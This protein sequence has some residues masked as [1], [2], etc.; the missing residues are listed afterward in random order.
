VGSLINFPYSADVRGSASQTLAAVYESASISG[1]ELGSMEMAG[2]YL[3]DLALKISQQI[4]EED[5]SVDVETLHAEAEALS[6][7]L[8]SVYI[9]LEDHGEQL[10][11]HYTVREARSVVQ[12]CM[13]ALVSC[14][15][16]R[17]DSASIKY[18]LNGIQPSEDEI[19]VCDELLQGEQELLMPLVDSVGYNL[20]FFRHDFLP[21]FESLVVP[22][23]APYLQPGQDHRARVAAVCLFD[24]CIEHCGIAAASKFAPV[25]I[26]GAVSGLEDVSE[27]QDLLRASIYGIAQISR[28]CPSSVLR[29][30][31]ARIVPRLASILKGS[32]REGNEAVFENT[33]STLA[34]LTL[35]GSPPFL[36]NQVLAREEFL[37]ILLQNSPLTVDYDESKICN[38]GLCDLIDKGAIP[39]DVSTC[40][41]VLRI[42]GEVLHLVENG[43]AV[44]TSETCLRFA[45]FLFRMQHEVP[46]EFLQ[47]CFSSLS[48]DAQASVQKAV[49]QY[50]HE[51]GAVV[52]P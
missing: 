40:R 11:N 36:N 27:D 22:V 33:I 52:T 47:E 3:P 30:Y 39:L 1:A 20:K 16:R 37:L 46:R 10:L 7:I 6:E 31:E 35:F 13:S 18:G 50:A 34:S 9:H 26:D 8:R 5:D 23:L 48:P 42:I 15:K 51:V 28:Y 43:E 12:R 4:V 17:D 21:I 44:A 45:S 49:G 2:R 19:K 32:T 24:D 25:L 41:E 29:P 38:A 14:L